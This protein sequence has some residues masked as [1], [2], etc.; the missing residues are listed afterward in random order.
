MGSRHWFRTLLVLLMPFVEDRF[1]FVEQALRSDCFH[2]CLLEVDAHMI[3]TLQVIFLVL[4][5]PNFVETLNK[6]KQTLDKIP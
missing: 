4:F 6:C 1:D 2:V 5:A 3:Q